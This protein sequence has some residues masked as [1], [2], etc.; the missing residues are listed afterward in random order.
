MRSTMIPS[1]QPPMPQGRKK[2][3]RDITSS[4]GLSLALGHPHR[5]ILPQS[6]SS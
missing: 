3:R 2:I 6:T 1:S 4:Y 5:R